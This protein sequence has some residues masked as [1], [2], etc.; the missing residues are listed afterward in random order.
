MASRMSTLGARLDVPDGLRQQTQGLID[1][2][3]IAGEVRVG[4]RR[5]V[6][7]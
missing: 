4:Q 3:L 2:G 7:G 6:L 5:D 1:G